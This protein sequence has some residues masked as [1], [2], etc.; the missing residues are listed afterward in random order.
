MVDKPKEMDPYKTRCDCYHKGTL[1]GCVAACAVN[2]TKY[3]EELA[4]F[5]DGLEVKYV[6]DEHAS[7]MA[8]LRGGGIKLMTPIS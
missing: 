1:V 6:H 4:Q 2:A 3:I 8:Q 7:V 5:Y